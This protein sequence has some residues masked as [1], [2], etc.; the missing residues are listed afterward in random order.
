LSALG[1]SWLR[2]FTERVHGAWRRWRLRN[3]SLCSFDQD[4][5][6]SAYITITADPCS[7]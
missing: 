6:K 1:F 2:W 3:V 4:K 5:E 7:P